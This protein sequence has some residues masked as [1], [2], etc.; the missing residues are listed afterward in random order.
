MRVC[1]SSPRPSR[2]GDI[3]AFNADARSKTPCDQETC[4]A[5]AALR[6]VIVEEMWLK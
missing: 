4:A 3:V 2:S 1:A 5:D 6:E